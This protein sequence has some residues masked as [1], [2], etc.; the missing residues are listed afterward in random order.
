MLLGLAFE[1]T[2][3]MLLDKVRPATVQ[4]AVK[5]LYT[6]RKGAGLIGRMLEGVSL[7]CVDL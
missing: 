7:S 6:V 3:H 1:Q 4:G 5:K 2:L